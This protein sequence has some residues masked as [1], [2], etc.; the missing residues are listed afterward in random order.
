[1]PPAVL[2]WLPFTV[3]I[4]GII[5]GMEV[6]GSSLLPWAVLVFGLLAR[7]AKPQDFTARLVIAA[8][9]GL[10]FYLDWL[11]ELGHVFHF[12]GVPIL[13]AVLGLLNFL[14][15]TLGVACILFIV[16]P[17]K[18][19]PALQTVDSFGPM[20]C[21]LLI[22]WL[23]L[24]VVLLMVAGII[25]APSEILNVVLIGA[26][27]LL[28][29]VAYFG[30]LMFAAPVA[31]DELFVLATPGPSG[32]TKQSLGNIVFLS[33]FTGSLFTIAWYVRTRGEMVKNYNIDL[34]PSWHLI[35]PILNIIWLWKWAGAVQTVTGGKTSQIIAFLFGFISMLIV[36]NTF[37]NM[38]GNVPTAVAG[39]PQGGGQPPQGYPQQGQPW[40]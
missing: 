1:V 39:Y 40:Q 24:A 12:S 27:L 16:P 5:Y 15:E 8:G 34:P 37:N 26:H 32:M 9:A 25:H 14:V 23:P 33:F 22:I 2:H 20:I 17:Q 7:I 18:L 35:V 13:E 4:L 36:Q 21:A 19:P 31:Y 38:G 29:I 6:V 11:P 3:S 10:M 28:P 30:M